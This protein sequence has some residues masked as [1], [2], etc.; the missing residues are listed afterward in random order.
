MITVKKYSS[1][2]ELKS[3]ENKPRDIKAI[4]RKHN[5]FAKFIET[6]KTVFKNNLTL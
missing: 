5:E 2:K 4:L 6:I 3:V 1:F